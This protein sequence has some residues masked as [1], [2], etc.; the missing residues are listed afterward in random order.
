VPSRS[1][2]PCPRPALRRPQRSRKPRLPTCAVRWPNGCP[3]WSW[4][5]G[6]HL[7]ARRRRGTCPRR[8]AGPQPLAVVSGPGSWM[9][10]AHLRTSLIRTSA[11]AWINPNRPTPC[12][13][14]A[15]CS[16]LERH[17]RHPEGR[18][19]GGGSGIRTHGA[20]RHNGFRDRPIRPLSH[21]SNCNSWKR[22][23][24]VHELRLRTSGG[25]GR[26]HELPMLQARE[27][28]PN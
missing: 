3:S 15:A 21:P 18:S 26:S 17:P 22:P 8:S 25:V 24:L 28:C 7:V 9:P 19:I 10:S 23:T 14:R 4:W 6:P 13:C 1:S 27:G 5:C 2:R 20:L 11:N 12:P 16:R